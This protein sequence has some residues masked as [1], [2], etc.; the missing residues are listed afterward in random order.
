V[1]TA[2]VPGSANGTV[3]SFASAFGQSPQMLWMNL[4]GYT[5]AKVKPAWSWS[6][7]HGDPIV[8]LV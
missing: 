5:N 3:V 4:S 2:T 6:A 7:A 1:V 8:A